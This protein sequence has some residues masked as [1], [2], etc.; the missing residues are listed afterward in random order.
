MEE[1]GWVSAGPVSASRFNAG[2]RPGS[3]TFPLPCTIYDRT[4]T[5]VGMATDWYRESLQLSSIT[6]KVNS[7]VRIY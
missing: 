6:M 3:M 4:L 5:E 1:G 2:S 7:V